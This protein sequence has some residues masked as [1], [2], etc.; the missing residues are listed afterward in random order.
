VI[1]RE[2]DAVVIAQARPRRRW[3]R[4][5]PAADA[6]VAR[7]LAGVPEHRGDGDRGSV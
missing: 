7:E 2:H 5:H 1:G 6:V 3:S 4:A